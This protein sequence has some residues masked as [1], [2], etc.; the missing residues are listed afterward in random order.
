[1]T[2]QLNQKI[3]V[4]DDA[5]HNAGRVGF[6]EFRGQGPSACILVLRLEQHKREPYTLIAINEKHAIVA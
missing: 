3:T 2:Y 4:A 1:M 6:F 5:P